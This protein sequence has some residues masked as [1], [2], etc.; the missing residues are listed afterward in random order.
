MIPQETIEQVRQATDIAQIIGEY[1]RLKRKGRHFEGL[2]PFHT[3]KTPSFKVNS[4]RQIYHCFGCGKGGNV[5]T[6][7]MEHEKMTFIEAIRHLASKA[8]ITIREAATDYRREELEKLNWAHQVALEYFE[9]QLGSSKYKSVLDSYLLGK[10]AIEPEVAQFFH[11]GLAGEEWDGLLQVARRKGLTDEDM[12]KAGLA[13]RSD[14]TNQCFDRFRQRLMIPIF[15]LSQKPIAFG[16][17]TLKKGEPAKYINSPETPLYS[18]GNVLYGLN[19]SKDTIRE[20]GHALVVEGY[21]DFISLWQVGVR[22]VV[23]SSGTA[24]TQQQARLLA[25]FCDLVYLFFDADSAGQNAALRSVDV[26][27]DSGLDVRVMIP[28]PG[29]DPDSTAR[30]FGPD[31]LEELKHAALGFIPFRIRNVSVESSGIIAKEKLVKELSALGNK[32]TDP[33]R[34]ALFFEEAAT[35]L[36]V[37]SALMYG[38]VP[39]PTERKTMSSAA[40]S[41]RHQTEM[42]YLS[43]LLG[44]PGS[45]DEAFETIAPEDL[46]SKELHRLYMAMIQQYREFGTLNANRLIESFA[47]EQMISLLSELA[48]IDW[49]TGDVEAETRS[50]VKMLTERK[51]KKI[52]GELQKQLAEAEA[53][54]D[55]KRAEELLVQIRSFGL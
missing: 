27:Y 46:D 9:S 4:D 12:I 19:F 33:T 31:K 28:P 6:F 26:L 42:E 24:F 25:R 18:K 23:A 7:L 52:R 3:E 39:K 11:I 2:C 14:S 20:S 41:R 5:F 40:R 38:A 10:R 29:E 45:L 44:N 36:S 8:N 13:L 32:I 30:K 34:R 48:T 37:D 50:Y 15:N 55:H 53:K 1:V 47:D 17:R 22:N 49:P 43:L 35:S 54:G 21:F 16:G 51:R